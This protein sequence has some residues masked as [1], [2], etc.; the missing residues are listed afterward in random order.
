MDQTFTITKKEFKIWRHV[1]AD[2]LAVIFYS[3]LFLF[4]PFGVPI[5]CYAGLTYSIDDIIMFSSTCVCLFCVFLFC[6]FPLVLF[7]A[8]SEKIRLP[9]SI[10]LADNFLVLGNNHEKQY[11]IHYSQCRYTV[12][13]I[14]C[15]SGSLFKGTWSRGITLYVPKEFLEGFPRGIHDW[16]GN[17]PVYMSFHFPVETENVSDFCSFLNKRNCRQVPPPTSNQ[18]LT[19]VF[20]PSLF[21]WVHLIIALFMVR[22]I[23]IYGVLGSIV[24][25]MVSGLLLA[26]SAIAKPYRKIEYIH[27][28]RSI[29]FSIYAMIILSIGLPIYLWNTPQHIPELQPSV[30]TALFIVFLCYV[31]S[32]LWRYCLSKREV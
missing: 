19:H 31:E 16:G 26:A 2:F 29:Q 13:F 1:L 32:Y 17:A 6:V 9:I 23:G 5:L 3:L 10:K 14:H 15:F 30:F 20:A 4:V 12:A 21:L 11:N 24:I 7:A 22:Q 8:L 18:L 27:Q 28:K 25:G